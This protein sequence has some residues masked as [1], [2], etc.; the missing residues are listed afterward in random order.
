[1]YRKNT[2]IYVID[3]DFRIVYSNDLLRRRVPEFEYG[4][5][6]YKVFCGEEN[7]CA[8][9]P[10]RNENKGSSILLHKFRNEW[11]IVNA[12]L[13]E[14]PGV[15]DC[16]LLT[17]DG[18]DDDGGKDLF[19]STVGRSDYNELLELNY[20]ND[21]YRVIYHAERRSG[22]RNIYGRISTIV[23]KV[24]E[25]SVHPDDR[26]RYL[27]FW[28]MDK[29]GV[30]GVPE[31]VLSVR[32]GEFR[33]LENDGSY[34]LIQQVLM[35]AR[36]STDA[37]IIV[38]S[39]F[40]DVDA[41]SRTE[42]VYPL[43]Q[44]DFG[45]TDLRDINAF[46]KRAAELIQTAPKETRWCMVAIDIENFKVFNSWYGR[47]EG[48]LLLLDISNYCRRLQDENPNT[49]TGYFG[50]DDFVLFM[51]Y[52]KELTERI[53]P[54]I[55]ALVQARS[56]KISVLPAVGI[57]EIAD[58]DERIFSMYDRAK[59][60]CTAVK[61]NYAERTKKFDSAMLEKLESELILFS[62]IQ[63]A[64]R[65]KEFTFY[66]QPKCHL[67]TGKIVGAEALVRWVHPEKGLVMPGVFI[68]FLERSGLISGVDTVIWEDA[69]RW[70]RQ[71]LDRGGKVLPVSVNVSRADLYAMDV[72]SYFVELVQKYHL[73]PELLEIEITE[74]VYAEDDRFIG[75]VVDKLHSAG[76]HVL[77]DDFGSAYSSLNM[78]QSITMD[79]LK[80]DMRF[81]RFD[82]QKTEKSRTLIET[83]SAMA[84][85]LGFRL[86][87]EG[88]ETS[89]Q[90]DFLVKIGCCYGQGYFFYRPLSRDAY[91]KLLEDEKNISDAGIYT[92]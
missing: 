42:G 52:N 70:L 73:T 46:F 74:G 20:Q 89:E 51:P 78:L 35:P 63:T 22:E 88:V 43:L 79:V 18:M 12:T 33:I 53:C 44:E 37:D 11:V 17:V 2:H 6:C 38:V 49:L 5:R 67:K 56:K 29:I 57:Y 60:A 66:L 26:A 77:M 81:L 28:L 34:R 31:E 69:C 54:D 1:M 24:A 48:S 7:Q 9:C 91:E 32:H 64:L 50:N 16:T 85:N 23:R 86:I 21:S 8:K 68:P 13:I 80:L 45:K 84:R 83:V 90:R 72:P 27:E 25:I 75:L 41:L 15:G 19:F 55:A 87:V 14:W 10:L 30:K 36:Q 4:E 61:G 65:N 62:D 59:F 92:S 82:G 3:N 71:M 40:N 76:F 47:S 39:F 58:T